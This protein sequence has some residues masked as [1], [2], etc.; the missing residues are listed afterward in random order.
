M[1]PRGRIDW[2]IFK[3]ILSGLLYWVCRLSLFLTWEVCKD[4]LGRTGLQVWEGCYIP[5]ARAGGDTG[6]DVKHGEL[7]AGSLRECKCPVKLRIDNE[8]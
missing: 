2:L 3:V 8:L 1:F 5:S 7:V 4:C 6:G